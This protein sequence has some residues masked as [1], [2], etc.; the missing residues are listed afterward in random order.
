MR[1]HVL[2]F[3]SKVH[4]IACPLRRL[5]HAYVVEPQ[6]KTSYDD[7]NLACIITLPPYQRKGYGML[8]IEFSESSS[9]FHPG[10]QSTSHYHFIYC[11][12]R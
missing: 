9:T 4:I 11:R 12:L 2:G 1:D 6:E 3:F 10:L 7:Y 8:L 5:A